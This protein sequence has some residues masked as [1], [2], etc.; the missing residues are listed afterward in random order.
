[1]IFLKYQTAEELALKRV[2]HIA[3]DLF[4]ERDKGGEVNR[5]SLRRCEKRYFL[6]ASSFTSKLN[7]AILEIT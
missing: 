5:Q 6:P 1:M 4:K 7:C 2:P 3:N